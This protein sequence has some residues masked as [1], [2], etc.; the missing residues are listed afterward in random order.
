MNSPATTTAPYS[1]KVERLEDQLLLG[2]AALREEN[3]RLKDEL[4]A[5]YSEMEGLR[6]QNTGQGHNHADQVRRD[7]IE[8]ELQI[9]LATVVQQRKD[10]EKS[11]RDEMAT[12]LMHHGRLQIA[13]DTLQHNHRDLTRQHDRARMELDKSKDIQ[14]EWKQSYD[15]LHTAFTASVRDLGILETDYSDLRTD[16]DTVRTEKRKLQADVKVLQ[17]DKVKLETAVSKLQLGHAEEG[18]EKTAM[19]DELK[20]ARGQLE[21]LRSD[22]NDVDE[23]VRSLVSQQERMEHEIAS[24]DSAKRN[25][26]ETVFDLQASQADL[27]SDLRKART[28]NSK[29]ELAIDKSRQETTKL[30][31]DNKQL[32]AQVSGPLKAAKELESTQA[33]MQAELGECKSKE[34]QL[35]EQLEVVNKRNDELTTELEKTTADNKLLHADI[36]SGSLYAKQLRGDLKIAT[37]SSQDAN[38][39]VTQITKQL[40]Q[41]KSDSASAKALAE[42]KQGMLTA[43][44]EQAVV[45]RDQHEKAIQ[46]IQD[47]LEKSRADMADISK[48]LQQSQSE[49]ADALV[50][51]EEA[52]A[53]KER[54]AVLDDRIRKGEETNQQLQK[55]LATLK[56]D[57][58]TTHKQLQQ[59]RTRFETLQK[60]TLP[61]RLETERLR[62]SQKKL[63]SERNLLQHNLNSVKK[64]RNEMRIEHNL[65]QNSLDSTKKERDELHSQ[66]SSQLASASVPPSPSVG[67]APPTPTGPVTYA[68]LPAGEQQKEL[69][70]LRDERERFKQYFDWVKPDREKLKVE[71]DALRAEQEVTHKA[72]KQSESEKAALMAEIAKYLT[73][74]EAKSPTQS[75]QPPG[76][77]DKAGLE[78]E[79]K[80]YRERTDMR[81][82]ELE[83]V[84]QLEMEKMML[85]VEFEHC[86][87]ENEKFRSMASEKRYSEERKA[88]VEPKCQPFPILTSEIYGAIAGFLSGTNSFGSLAN[89]SLANRNIH[90]ATLPAL[91]ETLVFDDDSKDYAQYGAIFNDD[92]PL[93]MPP[94]WTHTKQ[95]FLSL[96]HQEG[97]KALVPPSPVRAGSDPQPFLITAFPQLRFHMTWL[98]QKVNPA[99]AH[100]SGYNRECALILHG[101]VAARVLHDVLTTLPLRYWPTEDG[102]ALNVGLLSGITTIRCR[103]DARIRNGRAVEASQRYCNRAGM[104]LRVDFD[105]TD[106]SVLETLQEL[107]LLLRRPRTS[108]PNTGQGNA[109]MALYCFEVTSQVARALFQA[110]YRI[111]PSAI[112]DVT[113]DIVMS[114]TRDM[115]YLRIEDTFS[116]AVQTFEEICRQIIPS[117]HDINKQPNRASNFHLVASTYEGHHVEGRIDSRGDGKTFVATLRA[118]DLSGYQVHRSKKYPAILPKR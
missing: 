111:I 98:M 73:T 31:N 77:Q 107:M 17:E 82:A 32:K 65:L 44:E 101:I 47:E 19:R 54:V 56:T 104:S 24:A 99:E 36:A 33:K 92:A 114:K 51:R 64:E 115:T 28:A 35:R 55:Y 116:A 40:D 21:Q 118:T 59:A 1:Q 7:G 16:L 66:I 50:S 10:I 117:L 38:Q 91:F 80:A 79:Y 90:Y 112:H 95:L 89:L 18:G 103:P 20:E 34:A 84:A 30:R 4:D 29:L 72:L 49:L 6:M 9:E 102:K 70:R 22:K 39:K 63:E 27:E 113:V 67:V 96:R 15:A 85:E 3:D 68:V 62:N 60:E 109:P 57:K 11:L 23:Q 41:I 2:Q 43:S 37:K 71:N 86:R 81:L 87:T 26:S 48:A 46:Q 100:P 74:Q 14:V 25:L 110:I 83:D 8:R 97:I 108:T 69:E 12:I 78:A 53:S 42:K 88:K 106:A 93:G 45:V 105:S 5:V 94:G 13:T 61:M 52:K 76:V 58:A 75:Q